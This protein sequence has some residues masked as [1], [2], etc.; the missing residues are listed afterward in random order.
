MKSTK[1][2]SKRVASFVMIYKQ[3]IQRCIPENHLQNC[4]HLPQETVHIIKPLSYEV[5]GDRL[6]IIGETKVFQSV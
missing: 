5:I 1:Q 3:V 4:K 6:H 2:K